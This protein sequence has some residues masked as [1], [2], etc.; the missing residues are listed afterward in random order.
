MRPLDAFHWSAWDDFANASGSMS[1]LKIFFSGAICEMKENF[2]MA[3]AHGARGL[4]LAVD[5]ELDTDTKL[6]AYKGEPVLTGNWGGFCVLDPEYSRDEIVLAVK[7]ASVKN[8]ESAVE[9]L[10]RVAA[11]YT[12]FDDVIAATLPLERRENDYTR[13]VNLQLSL[14]DISN[15]QSLLNFFI[16][17]TKTFSLSAFRQSINEARHE[18]RYHGINFHAL[19]KHGTIEIRYH[20]GTIEATKILHW[21][22]LHQRILDLSAD[23]DNARF[24]LDRLE[25]ANMVVNIEQKANLFFKKLGLEAATE[26]YFRARIK[27]FGE[28]D[29]GL[30][31]SLL[32]DDTQ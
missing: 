23:L 13:R 3:V 4:K 25:K 6:K 27:E 17:W 5:H 1:Y 30:V 28:E 12:V 11:F 18:S 31:N 2:F 8:C 32:E 10:K 20:S 19:L 9:R 26:R 7:K 22:A 21:T 29:E 14:T 15:V 24:N 16:L